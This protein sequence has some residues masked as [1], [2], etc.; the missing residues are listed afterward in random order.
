M[1][2]RPEPAST[3]KRAGN[4]ENVQQQSKPRGILS[5]KKPNASEK[6]VNW[7]KCSFED[8]ERCRKGEK[9]NNW[10]PKGRCYD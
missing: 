2:K 1:K 9:C 10:H 4:S 3:M 7:R 8:S 6:K 5:Y